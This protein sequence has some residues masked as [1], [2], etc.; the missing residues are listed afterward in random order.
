MQNATAPQIQS[1]E[2]ASAAVGE[3]VTIRG[4]RLGDVL[5]AI[6]FGTGAI[7]EAETVHTDTTITCKVP[8]SATST[9]VQ[10]QTKTTG[11]SNVFPFLIK[12]NSG[13]GT[14]PTWFDF[15]FADRASDFLSDGNGAYYTSARDAAW[16]HN[17]VSDK[18]LLES[19]SGSGRLRYLSG[20]GTGGAI[21]LHHAQLRV[22]IQQMAYAFY[23]AANGRI[24][25]S[26]QG[27]DVSAQAAQGLQ[28]AR[29]GYYYC[30]LRTGQRVYVQESADGVNFHGLVEFPSQYDMGGTLYW[31]FDIFG[32]TGGSSLLQPQFGYAPAASGASIGPKW[33]ADQW[34]RSGGWTSYQ[35]TS[36]SEAVG[37]LIYYGDT[38]GLQASYSV[39]LTEAAYLAGYGNHSPDYGS[40][41][42]YANGSLLTPIYSAY[43]S[44]GSPPNAN[45]PLWRSATLFQPGT[46]TL[47]FEI[48]SGFVVLDTFGFVS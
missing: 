16:G 39:T 48:A 21:G 31:T 43:A 34:T 8:A 42:I 46:Y 22:P 23:I 37:A 25:L 26:V 32:D 33:Y 2:P 12:T 6:Y 13:G 30:L 20:R 5:H 45:T 1:I 27:V 10:V 41:K 18:P 24:V 28:V 29:D 38:V 19:D 7:T 9:G 47:L 17:A 44:S 4:V 11:N 3:T 14:A 40:A 15:T 36:G 35:N